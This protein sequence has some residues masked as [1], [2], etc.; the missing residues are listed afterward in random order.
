LSIVLGSEI[1]VKLYEKHGIISDLAD[2]EVGTPREQ[3]DTWR[4]HVME[5]KK[6]ARSLMSNLKQKHNAAIVKDLYLNNDSG[7]RRLV[8]MDIRQLADPNNVRK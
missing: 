4:R 1:Q 7:A 5:A 6:H 2:D 8:N 3:V